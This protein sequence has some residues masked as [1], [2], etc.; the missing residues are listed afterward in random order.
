MTVVVSMEP[1]ACRCS[2]SIRRWQASRLGLGG[3]S[4][5]VYRML[6]GNSAARAGPHRRRKN[7]A[8]ARRCQ[9]KRE[10]ESH[11]QF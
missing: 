4:V 3:Y 2:S 1:P 10:R 8:I 5:G 11:R 7:G 6:A 9:S